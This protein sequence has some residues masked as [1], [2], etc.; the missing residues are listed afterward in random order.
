VDISASTSQWGYNVTDLDV[1]EM[2]KAMVNYANTNSGFCI[3]HQVEDFYRSV[4]FAS[5]DHP[6]AT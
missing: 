5:S 6:D 4:S 1:T 3:M 2:V